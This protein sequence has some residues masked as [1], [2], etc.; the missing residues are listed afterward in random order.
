[1]SL[2]ADIDMTAL[3]QVVGGWIRSGMIYPTIRPK[4]SRKRSQNMWG[5]VLEEVWPEDIEDHQK[6]RS[7][8]NNLDERVEWATEKL[9]NWKGA[10]RMAWDQW[11]FDNKQNAEKFITYYYLTWEA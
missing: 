1:M 10:R 3:Q 8:S 7:S 6:I 2:T 5:I 9:K 4:L 11:Y